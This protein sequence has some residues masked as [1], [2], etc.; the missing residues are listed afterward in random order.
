[1]PNGGWGASVKRFLPWPGIEDWETTMRLST[2][3]GYPMTYKHPSEIME[4]IARLTPTFGGVTY[5]KLEELGSVQWPCNEKASE[6][7]PIIHVGGF[8][9]GKGRFMITEFVPADERTTRRFPPILTT[10]GIMTWGRTRLA[11]R[12]MFG[13]RRIFWRFTPRTRRIAG[14]KR[15][16]GFLW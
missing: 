13:I 14:S 7:T 10:G 4:E 2:A 15:V 9:R 1:M 12:I 11:R 5:E 8:A 6:G 3:M 16:T